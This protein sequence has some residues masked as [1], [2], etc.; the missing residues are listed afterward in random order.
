MKTYIVTQKNW[1]EASLVGNTGL[2]SFSVKAPSEDEAWDLAWE[3]VFDKN[4]EDLTQVDEKEKEVL[5]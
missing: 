2:S 3:S 4:K 1:Y 5:A